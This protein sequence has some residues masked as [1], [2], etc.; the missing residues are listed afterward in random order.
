MAGHKFVAEEVEV[1]QRWAS[2]GNGVKG[3]ICQVAA[4]P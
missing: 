4:P 3:R 1:E 2:S